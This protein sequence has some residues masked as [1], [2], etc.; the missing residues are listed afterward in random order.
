M[1][2]RRPSS[3]WCV[4]SFPC[5]E[6]GGRRC[7]HCGSFERTR[8]FWLYLEQTGVLEGAKRFLHFAPE[9]GLR[10][11]LAEALGEGYTTAGLHMPR[12]DHRGEITRLRFPDGRFDFIYCSNVLEHVRDDRAA[13]A[14]LYRVLRPGGTAIIQS[15]TRDE[16]TVEAPRGDRSRRA[17]AFVWP[18]GPCPLPWP[19]PRGAARGRR[20]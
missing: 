6:A 8:H 9:P 10:A 19:G 20:L 15:P 11:R 7:P 17:R 12:V 1:R 4:R 14:E 18:G 5:G 16:K 13:M 2:W 3:G